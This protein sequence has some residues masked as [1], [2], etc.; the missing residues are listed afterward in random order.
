MY[1]SL[2][3]TIRFTML[4]CIKRM[5]HITYML[6]LSTSEKELVCDQS[7]W[8]ARHRVFNYD[9]FIADVGV[10][11]VLYPLKGNGTWGGKVSLTRGIPRAII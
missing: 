10:C 3:E 6:G 4:Q 11:S 9:A 5:A 7:A 8:G 1:H 2:V